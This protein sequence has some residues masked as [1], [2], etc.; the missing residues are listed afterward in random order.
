[1]EQKNK[2]MP[3]EW[4]FYTYFI[5]FYIFR[6]YAEK[7]ALYP[8]AAGQW[9]CLSR[10]HEHW[11]V[12]QIL[13]DRIGRAA[14]P[15]C[16]PNRPSFWANAYGDRPARSFGSPEESYPTT[17]QEKR[18]PLKKNQEKRGKEQGIPEG[19]VQWTRTIN[20]LV[21]PIRP[22]HLAVLSVP[23]QAEGISV[24]CWSTFSD[25]TYMPK[26]NSPRLPETFVHVQFTSP[27]SKL[28]VCLTSSSFWN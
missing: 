28:Y 25:Q 20:V 13:D 16:K 3:W 6:N 24:G 11:P 21:V 2:I 7:M 27:I 22:L 18:S 15:R 10:E 26:E 23:A 8:A 5:I 4:L 9:A 17:Q 1:M 19:T 14:K 12:E